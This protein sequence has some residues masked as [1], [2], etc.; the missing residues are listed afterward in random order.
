MKRLCMNPTNDGDNFLE[1]YGYT[2]CADWIHA[3]RPY[4]KLE[5]YLAKK[6]QELKSEGYRTSDVENY[7]EALE[8][9]IEEAFGELERASFKN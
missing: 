5:K 2:T 1:D 6:G 4:E 3:S 9:W 7:L 8:E